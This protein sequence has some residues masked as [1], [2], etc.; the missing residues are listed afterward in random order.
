MILVNPLIDCRYKANN[1]DADMRNTFVIYYRKWFMIA[2]HY[3]HCPEIYTHYR[4]LYCTVMTSFPVVVEHS[5]IGIL[6]L[7]SYSRTT[8]LR[9]TINDTINHSRN[10]KARSIAKY[11]L[12]QTKFFSCINKMEYGIMTRYK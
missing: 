12:W 6:L 2:C 4:S 7:A 5:L 9:Q 8:G 1:S 10:V 11:T 3:S